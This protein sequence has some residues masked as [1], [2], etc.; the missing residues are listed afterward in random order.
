MSASTVNGGNGRESLDGT[1]GATSSVPSERVF[2]VSGNVVTPKRATLADSTI[3]DL[4]FLHDN[5]T[6]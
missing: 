2:S 5:G 3:R 4:V 6:K 1:D